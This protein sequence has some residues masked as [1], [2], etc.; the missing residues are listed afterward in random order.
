MA[1]LTVTETKG[2]EC[3][4]TAPKAVTKIPSDWAKISGSAG[5]P[6]NCLP[7]SVRRRKSSAN[8]LASAVL[9]RP[10]SSIPISRHDRELA[11]CRT[12]AHCVGHRTQAHR[13]RSFVERQAAFD[14]RFSPSGGWWRRRLS[15]P[16]PVR[17]Y[18]AGLWTALSVTIT[19]PRPT[20]PPPSW[21][22]L[23]DRSGRDPARNLNQEVSTCASA[24][25]TLSLFEAGT[26]ARRSLSSAPVQ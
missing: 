7:T 26:V 14:A 25:R 20:V 15:Y 4:R 12:A 23:R 24:S 3:S 10:R 13:H 22:Q 8:E 9:R 1:A 18:G 19:P 11:G 5:D 2:P 21:P 6:P 16:C 17:K